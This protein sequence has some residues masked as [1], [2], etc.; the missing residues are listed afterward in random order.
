MINEK[1]G[2]NAINII[3]GA[4]GSLTNEDIDKNLKFIE[5]SEIFLTQL[6]TPYEAT[7]YAL[8][9]AKQSGSITIF[10][11]APASNINESD[12]KFTPLDQI[13]IFFGLGAIKGTG[14]SAIDII[15]EERK[16]NGP[17]TSLFDFA[18]RLDLRKVNRK[19]F[20]SLIR[21]GAF[22]QIHPNRASLLASVNLA[23]TKAEQG[24]AHQG[25]NALF[26]EFETSEIPLID[27]DIWEER[28][29]L[30]EEKIALGFYFSNH[31]F[32]FY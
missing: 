6:E 24:H 25:Q 32:K 16:S 12:Y 10:N 27:S 13:R 29:Q 30:A 11:P 17:F 7:S 26:E 18:S 31:P 15:L 21:A 3:S 2:D 9:K 28:K 19:A 1:T 23:I 20:E 8:N 14:L 5:N 22:D 4:A